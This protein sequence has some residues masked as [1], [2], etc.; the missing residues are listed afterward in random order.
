MMLKQSLINRII[1]RNFHFTI[2]KEDEKEDRKFKTWIEFETLEQRKDKENELY[3][4][5]DCMVET[6]E[7]PDETAY[8]YACHTYEDFEK[9]RDAR[10]VKKY[11]NEYKPYL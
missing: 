9:R 5:M 10:L 2:E 7:N 8:Y 4:Y 6:L 11:G 3:E 1:S